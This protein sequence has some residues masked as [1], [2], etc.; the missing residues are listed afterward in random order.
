[1]PWNYPFHNIFNPLMA[2]VF[3]GNSIVIKVPPFVPAVCLLC[4]SCAPMCHV[5]HRC[6]HACTDQ[7]LGLQVSE[8][9]SWSALQYGAIIEAALEAAG[10]SARFACT[11]LQA[12]GGRPLHHADMLHTL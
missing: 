8:H 7:C 6:M 12:T 4:T 5:L 2:A 1:M 11:L 9:A 10:M 3:A